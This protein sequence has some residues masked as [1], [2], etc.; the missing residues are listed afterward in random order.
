MQADEAEKHNQDGL[1]TGKQRNL[2]AMRMRSSI[3]AWRAHAPPRTH[4][5]HEG[6][7]HD[8]SN[9]RAKP[10]L[11]A[12][13]CPRRG[14]LGRALQRRVPQPP[15]PSDH[16]LMVLQAVAYR[17]WAMEACRPEK[18]KAGETAYLTYG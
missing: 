8:N 17:L 7:Q 13:S 3:A 5:T 4:P 6:K 1:N 16:V 10:R 2:C 18:L 15:K 11:R 9:H 12:A 14:Q